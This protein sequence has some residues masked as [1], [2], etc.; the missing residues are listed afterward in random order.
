MAAS[1]IERPDRV[2][3]SSEP[4]GGAERAG[5]GQAWPR[6]PLAFLGDALWWGAGLLG[7]LTDVTL[8]LL[9]P[10]ALAGSVLLGAGQWLSCVL[11]Q[12]VL[13]EVVF[14]GI[15]QAELLR[16]RWGGGRMGHVTVANAVCSVAFTGLH[17][18]HHPPLWAASVLVPSLIFGGL[19]E[20]HGTV[21]APMAMH[22]LYNLEFFS[23]ASLV[24]R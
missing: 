14:R 21:A 16:T 20:R 13:E 22:V 2:R 17:F 15:L 7:L 6:L 8:R 18:I 19:R 5:A 4:S 10:G 11:L 3:A 1:S 9:A 12:P 24:I 23:A